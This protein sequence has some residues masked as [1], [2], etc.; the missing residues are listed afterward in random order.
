MTLNFNAA[1]YY[2]NYDETN[3]FY[4]ILFKPGY[5]VQT[6]ELNQLQTII[7]KQIEV[8][9]KWLFKEGAMVLGG[10]SSVDTKANYVVFAMGT[11]VVTNAPVGTELVGGTSGITA[12]VVHVEDAS[13]VDLPTVFVKYTNSGSDTVTKTFNDDETIYDA[14]GNTVGLT[15][16]S[17]ATGLG[18]IASITSGFYFVKNT[19]VYVAD[20]TITLDKYSNTPSYKIGLDITESFV[21]ADMDTTLLDNAQ[22]SFNYAAPGADRYSIELTLVKKNPDDT[23]DESSFVQLKVVKNGT[24]IRSVDNTANSILEQTLA[25]RTYDESGD[26]TVKPFLIDVREYRNNFRG[27]WIAYEYYLAGDV[28]THNGN[29]YSCRKDGQASNTAPTQTVGSTLAN[30]TGVIW[31]YEANPFY[32]R[33]VN[34]VTLGESLITQ[35]EN[36]S[37]LAIGLE[38]GKAYVRG[39]EISKTSTEFITVPKARDTLQQSN[40][41]IPASVGNYVI[42]TNLHSLPNISTFPVVSLYNRLTAS[43]GSSAGTLVGTARVRFVEFN[44]DTA[45][46]LSTTK[47]KVSL[48]NVV[49]NPGYNFNRDV[50]QLYIAGGSTATNFTADISSVLI[51]LSGSVSVSSTT[52]TG[53]GSLF[54]TEF[55]VGDYISVTVGGT[56]YR[57]RITAIASNTSL[58]IDSTI[59]TTVTGERYSRVQTILLEPENE[60]LIFP[61]TRPYVKTIRD[62]DG[63]CNTSYTATKRFVKTAVDVGSDATITLN[64]TGT[65]TFASD[66]IPTNYLVID[67]TTGDVVN[68]LSISGT[69]TQQVVI[70]VDSD[71]EIEYVVYAAVNRTGVSTEKTKTLTT[72][73]VTITNRAL[74]TAP[75]ISLGKA[76]G[77]RILQ[78]MQD[79]GTFTSPTGVYTTDITSRYSFDD[80]Q[81]SSYYGLAKAILN[82]GETPPSAPVR[83]TFEYFAHSGTGDYFTVDSYTSSIAYDKIPAFNGIPLTFAFDFRPR[84]DDTGSTFG[85]VLMPKRGIDI[86]TDY[87]HYLARKDKVVLN[88]NGSFFTLQGTPAINPTDVPSSSTGMVLYNLTLLPYNYAPSS[89]L[90]ET[91]D[92][93]RYTMRDIGRLE[94]RIDNIEYYTSLSLLEQ[95]AQSLEIQD[96]DGFN[97]FKNGFIVDNFTGNSVSNIASPDYKC[98]I[99]MEN[100]L[101][102]PSY[103]MDNVKLIEKNTSNSQRATNGYQVTGDLV[104]LPYS[105]VE[106]V[107]QLDASRVENINPFAIFTFI[108][109]AILN[110][111]SDEWF[112]TKRLPD[113]HV[114]VEG[115]FNSIYSAAAASGALSGIWNAWQTQWTG[116][117]VN[118]SYYTAGSNWAHQRALNNGYTELSIAEANARFGTA[119]GGG[120]NRDIVSETTT[121][122]SGQTR[123][124][125]RMV[126]TPKVDTTTTG[127]VVISRAV[128]PYIRARSVLFVVRG[129]KPNTTF[130]PFFDSVN[131]GSQCTP[132]STIVVSRSTSFDA[133]TITGGDA[134]ESARLINGNVDSSLD[135]GDLIYV[136][137][138]G[139]TIYT[140]QTSPATAVLAMVTNPLNGTTTTLQVVNVKGTFIAGDVV[141]GSIS[142]ATA[143]I[144][145]SGITIHT[146]GNSIVTNSSGEVCGLFAIPN[147]DSSRFRTGTRE[148]KLS[149]DVTDNAVNRTSYVRKSYV[150][151]GVLSTTQ[152]TITST[153]NADVRSEAMNDYRTVVQT[154][155]R[156]VSDTGW[157][158]PLA[159]T[160]L[161]DSSGGAFVTSVDVFFASKD[162]EIP[163]RMQIREVVNG[164]PGKNILPFSEVILNPNQVNISTTTVTTGLG[165]VLP[166]PIATN[167]KFKSPV[168][169]NDKTE[170]CVVLMSDSNNYKAWI[171]QLGDKSVMSTVTDRII[172]EQPYMGVL[173]KSQNGS[174]WTGDQS[175]DLMFKI[176][177]ARFETGNYGEVDFINTAITTQALD[178]QPF[179]MVAGTNYIRVFHNN[180]GMFAGSDVTISGVT[181][182]TGG[183]SAAEFN[184]THTIVSADL[185]SYVIQLSSNATY[186][187]NFGGEGV[188]ATRNVQY[189]TVQPIVGQFLFPDT[190][191]THYIRTT[192]GKSVH[193]N[194]T[195]Y[196]VSTAF[197]PV[198]INE[199]N[200]L[201]DLQMIANADT[202]DS[203]LSGNNSVILRSRLIS[204]NENVSPAIDTSRLSLITI[205]DRITNSTN[206]NTNFT[207]LDARSVVSGVTTVAITNGNQI[208]TA[209][210]TTKAAFLTISVGKYITTTGFATT[211]N[212][213]TFL[214]TAVASDGSSITV[215]KALTNV[216][217]GA[218]VT[219]KCLDRFV[220]EIAPM[221]SSNAA[222]YVT[223]KVNLKNP[224]TFLKIRFAADIE[225][226]ANVNVYYKLELRNSSV[227][228][229]TIPYTLANPTVA[230]VIS[231]DGVFHD[232]EYDIADLPE[233]TAVQVK[234]VSTSTYGA[235]IV[236]V[237]DLQIVGCA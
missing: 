136:K 183:V 26:Y 116:K 125:I 111:S 230:P 50:K 177:K 70:T 73:T 35:R 140:K 138:R 222:K 165:E 127:D 96:S 8:T 5:A 58:T 151:E 142:G 192:S 117:N 224:S 106:M 47:Y 79:T 12:K 229:D 203:E 235:D 221:G 175:Q 20:Q 226:G 166:A 49:M 77:Y 94:K 126:V 233:F 170:Y 104:T 144:Q 91:I 133:E 30:N 197:D 23:S 112:E 152:A 105:E 194:E 211:S 182:T 169:L 198:T 160:F 228:F 128:I 75:T 38:P 84:I 66:A 31:T 100:G 9:G 154:S 209:D 101:M 208:S 131:V 90:I 16:S 124:G 186:T 218:T 205:Q 139:A 98:A 81:T 13:G 28:V 4:R 39:Y 44:S 213:G 200:N 159:Q 115:N 178:N 150:A 168:Y 190:D 134:T 210:A 217:A 212:N 76:D 147:T 161:V 25:R 19:F 232:I 121:T 120:P 102:R 99:D 62:E 27:E 15:K 215:N 219:V 69:D 173:F 74:A 51:P 149:D 141:G 188:I 85:E 1:P 223:K 234:I 202:E 172:S 118:T 82:V 103:Y 52:V 157:Y 184:T 216:S 87:Q 199:N 61:T 71:S 97:R 46:G 185:D 80:G 156:V 174:T 214:V 36:A 60:S 193:G 54:N 42:V 236:R 95:N 34:D 130:T 24:L 181:Q 237:R 2:D 206:E 29:F 153:R 41:K 179:F 22:G 132:A 63:N 78:V 145:T 191:M 220:D 164:Y 11:D 83:I 57:R 207:A 72:A 56:E 195:P 33:G 163:V 64:V 7:D 68:P 109:N 17:N 65:D 93:K 187:G 32:N 176:N 155:E 40:V 21:T 55:K 123:T 114:D 59:G 18:S 119:G 48:F 135:K 204:N 122:T 37:N 167:F 108:G 110:P 146:Q 196:S 148:F 10:V 92:N 113:I 227:D 88:Q 143:T 231:T 225:Q 43:A 67:N 89:V 189:N 45:P 201:M 180:H 129:L 53:T 3:G 137:Q 107:K 171:S 162:K 86:E 6:R 158:D 14:D